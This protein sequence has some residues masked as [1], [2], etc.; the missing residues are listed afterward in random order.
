MRG[1]PKTIGCKQDLI[2]LQKEYPKEVAAHLQLLITEAKTKATRVISGS[3][4]SGDLMT[5]EIDNP[6]PAWKRL[7][8]ESVDDVQKMIAEVQNGK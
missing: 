2:N 4:E 1:Y 7:G 8:F 6:S 5:E 3:E